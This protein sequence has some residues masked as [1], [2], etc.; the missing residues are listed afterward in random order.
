MGQLKQA[1]DADVYIRADQGKLTNKGAI[2]RASKGQLVDGSTATCTELN[3]IMDVDRASLKI[4]KNLLQFMKDPAEIKKVQD[5]EQAL[6][7][8]IEGSTGYSRR[9]R[10]P[11]RAAMTTKRESLARRDTL[12]LSRGMVLTLRRTEGYKHFAETNGVR[13]VNGVCAYRD[14][15]GLATPTAIEVVYMNY[16]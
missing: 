7:K 16:D 14:S 11:R 12:C 3:Q 6:E 13:I 9:R 1:G 5:V 2:E 15:R 4:E 8:Q 10:R